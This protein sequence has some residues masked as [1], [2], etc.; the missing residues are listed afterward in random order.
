MDIETYSRL[1]SSLYT[2]IK[3]Q[4]TYRQEKLK[5]LYLFSRLWNCKH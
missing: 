1:L 2:L 4:E 5:I 3:Q